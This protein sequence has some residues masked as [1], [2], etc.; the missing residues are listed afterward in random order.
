MVYERILHRSNCLATGKLNHMILQPQLTVKFPEIVTETLICSS[1]VCC[2]KELFILNVS[3][4][5]CL[6]FRIIFKSQLTHNRS[7]VAFDFSARF[8]AYSKKIEYRLRSRGCRIRL[9]CW[10]FTSSERRV[11][12]MSGI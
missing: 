11:C 2:Q 9:S 3:A 5:L 10:W 6:S 12:S 7:V 4:L 1:L 8:I